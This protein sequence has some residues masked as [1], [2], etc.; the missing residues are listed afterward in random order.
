M[1]LLAMPLKISPCGTMIVLLNQSWG[2]RA[3]MRVTKQCAAYRE[4]ATSYAIVAN[5]NNYALAA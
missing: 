3:L 4:P 2:D 1:G 5:D